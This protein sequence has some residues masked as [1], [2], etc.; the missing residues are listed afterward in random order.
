MEV[1]CS[2]GGEV[3]TTG[4]ELVEE[5]VT[6]EGRARACTASCASETKGNLHLCR[7][8]QRARSRSVAAIQAMHAELGD[9]A[10]SLYRH[11]YSRESLSNCG[12]AGGGDDGASFGRFDAVDYRRRQLCFPTAL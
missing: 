2:G 1:A 4:Q 6:G 11:S 12:V 10:R 9:V 7:A 3:T 8:P 5:R